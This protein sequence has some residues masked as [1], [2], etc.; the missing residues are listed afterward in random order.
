MVEA[1]SLLLH[2]VGLRFRGEAT[3]E[4]VEQAWTMFQGIAD[5]CGGPEAGIMIYRVFSNRDL[6][7]GYSLYEVI[8]FRD[9]EAVESFR[10]HP[11]HKKLTDF[12]REFA[13]WVVLDAIPGAEFFREMGALVER[14]PTT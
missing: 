10:N 2:T 8:V 9:A 11:E 1:S 13:D 5:K 12:I 4:Q 6:R 14:P 7:K 3:K